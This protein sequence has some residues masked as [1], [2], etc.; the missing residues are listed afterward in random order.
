[1]P[2]FSA[3]SLAKL[4]TCHPD[5]QRLFMRVVETWDCTI[6]EGARS[7]AQQR[8]NVASGVSK[9]MDSRHLD[10][11]SKAVDVTPFPLSWPKRLTEDTPAA[12]LKWMKDYARYYYFA[13]FVL[14]VA[15]EL[16]IRIRH[17]GDWDG[18]RDIHEQDFDDLPHFELRD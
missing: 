3:V 2:R 5:L 16:N 17:G 15:Q 14:G 12:R 13:G 9:T 4:S 10:N 6:L 8:A 11:P 7:L 18:D 1:M